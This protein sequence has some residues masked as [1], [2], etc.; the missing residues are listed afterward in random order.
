MTFFTLPISC[1][2]CFSCASASLAALF[3]LPDY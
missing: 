2:I 3:N 1:A